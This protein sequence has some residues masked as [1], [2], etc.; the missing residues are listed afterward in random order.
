M[1]DPLVNWLAGET[2]IHAN[3]LATV[4]RNVLVVR[5]GMRMAQTVIAIEKVTGLRKVTTTNPGFL[6][7]SCGL[8]T[9]AAASY[10]SKQGGNV[11]LPIAMVGAMFVMGYIGTRRAAVLFL[12]GDERIESIQGSFREATSVIRAVNRT[13]GSS[14]EMGV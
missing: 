8:F 10:F 11:T 7:I 14:V 5:D 12:M 4:T 6:V 3:A 1:S 13:R 2:V 9:I